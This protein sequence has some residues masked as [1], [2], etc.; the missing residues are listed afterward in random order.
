LLKEIGIECEVVTGTGIDETG[1]S[2]FH[3]WNKVR[4]DGTYYTLDATWDAGKD[5]YNYFLKSEEAIA[6]THIQ[7][8]E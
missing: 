2:E 5:E 8:G 1:K 4:L 3:A 7:S 6:S